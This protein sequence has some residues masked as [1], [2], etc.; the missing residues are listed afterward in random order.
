MINL[1]KK[2]FGVRI[3]HEGDHKFKIEYFD[4]RFFK[5]WKPLLEYQGFGKFS[6]W[7]YSY[8]DAVMQFEKFNNIDDVK[9]HQDYQKSL[10]NF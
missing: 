1:F 10:N 3:V 7:L 5:K 6:V 8:M 9:T 4:Y 2:K